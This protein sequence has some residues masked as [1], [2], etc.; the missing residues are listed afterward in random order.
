MKRPELPA[1]Q[2]LV[3]EA[4]DH[5]AT[6]IAYDT[7]SKNSNRELID[8]MASYFETLGG[9]LTIIPDKTGQK[10]NLVAR[11]GPEDR[12]GIV[13]S[14]HTD[15]VPA[16]E[17]GWVTPPFEMVERDGR[18]YGRGSCDMKGFVACV[19]ALANS[20]AATQLTKPLYLCFSYDEEVGCLGAPS[21]ARHLAALPVPPH[22]AIIGEPSE[23]KLIT[24]QKGKIAMRVVVKG[25]SGHSSFSPL[26]VNA[27]EYAGRLLALIEA[28]AAQYASQ[29]PFDPEF[30]VSH[31]TLTTTK[32]SGGVATNITP[33]RC[34]LTFELRSIGENDPE[35]ELTELL[36]Q[37]AEIETEM[38]EKAPGVGFEW[39]R[40][41]A[42][43]AMNDARNSAGFRSISHLV[44]N[45]GGKV[46]YGSEGGVFEKTGGIPSI[47]VGPGSIEQAHKPNEF[48][49]VRQ[50]EMCLQFLSSLVHESVLQG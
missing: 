24:G 27:V 29:G 45:Y 36:A 19:M 2:R 3:D 18:L 46:S 49:A 8:H 47:I 11:F 44:P 30:T 25:T 50:I 16:D 48:V 10:V 37:A 20:L 5:L 28:R 23:M 21:I 43:P 22:L 35:G 15:V 42:Y 1:I 32:I 4:K 40:L 26:H 17:D 12:P 9:A 6:L 14:G 33:D 13:L 41:F 31:A 7:V 38:Q 34:E 39:H